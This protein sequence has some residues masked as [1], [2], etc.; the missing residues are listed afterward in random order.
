MFKIGEFSKLSNT[1]VRTLHH[2]EK[3]ELLLPQE[4]DADSNYRYY[5]AEQLATINRIKMLQQ[6]GLSLKAIK[7]ILKQNNMAIL[8]QHY[9]LREVELQQEL[10]EL[11]KKQQI[12]Q[13]LKQQMKAGNF[14]EKYNVVIK[15]IP[16]RSVISLRK[17]LKTYAD[18]GELWQ[19]LFQAVQQQQIKLAEPMF[20]M[21]IYHDK[22]YKESDV[23]V[24]VQTQIVGEY[25]N[26]EEI[27]F[28]ESTAITIASVTFHGSFEQIPQVTHAI[29]SWI[30]ANQYKIVGPMIN[31]PHVSPAQ[32]P[33]PENWVTE[34]AFV[35]EK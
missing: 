21:S 11:A 18:E 27:Q 20:G 17:T 1:T 6:V 15:E 10:T 8:E 23:D 3:M 32:D 9:E 12:I 25:Q 14:M 7:E 5:A 35:V 24:E 34:A 28:F 29:A 13:T 4:I 16:Q 33:N 19:A 22:E 30:E 26:T 31:I 2:Y